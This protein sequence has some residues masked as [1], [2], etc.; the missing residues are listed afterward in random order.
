MIVSS[1]YLRQLHV[2]ATSHTCL[3]VCVRLCM[4]VCAEYLL[5]AWQQLPCGWKT[6]PH[7]WPA[8]SQMVEVVEVCDGSLWGSEM[9]CLVADVISFQVVGRAKGDSE[10]MI[11]LPQGHSAALQEDH[12]WLPS[13]F[14]RGIQL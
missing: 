8:F 11:Q 10:Q 14:A 3:C 9:L 2:C 4:C 7:F 6:S 13:V 1:W 12:G 5:Q